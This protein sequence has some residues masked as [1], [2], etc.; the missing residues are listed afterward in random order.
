MKSMFFKFTNS[1]VTA[2]SFAKVVT[3]YSLENVMAR[4]GVK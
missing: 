1:S 3:D 4:H 2:D